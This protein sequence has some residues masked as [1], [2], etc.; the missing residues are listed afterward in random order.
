MRQSLTPSPETTF[1]RHRE[2][3]EAAPAAQGS[4]ERAGRLSQRDLVIASLVCCP[5]RSGGGAPGRRVAK[6]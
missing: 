1:D 6:G 5:S 3:P 4:P 2:A